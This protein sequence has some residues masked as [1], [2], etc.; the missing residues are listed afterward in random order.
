MWS[1]KEIIEYYYEEINYYSFG[2]F[3]CIIGC[4]LRKMGFM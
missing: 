2:Y 1:R 3:D 4:F